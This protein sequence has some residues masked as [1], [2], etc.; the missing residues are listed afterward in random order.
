M[1]HYDADII[2]VQECLQKLPQ[3]LTNL[4]YKYMYLL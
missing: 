3:L 1:L 4:F 2:F